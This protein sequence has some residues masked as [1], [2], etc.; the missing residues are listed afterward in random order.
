MP[1]VRAILPR[2]NIY[3]HTRPSRCPRCGGGMLHRHGEVQKRVKDIYV[4]EVAAMRYRCVGCGRSFTHY[5]QGVDRNGC[6]VRL[7]ALMSLMWALG[8]S[9]RSVGCVLTA[10]GRPA[11]RMSS[12][13]A[14]QEAG[15][16]AARSM[17]KR[18]M[19]GSAPVM[20]ADETIVKVRGKAKLAGFVA[21]AES[22][23]LLG[24][25]MPVE[26][27]GAGF[28]D[29]L[30]GYVE[31]LGVKAVVTDDL[32]TY[33]PVVDRLG[34]EHQICAAHVRKNA[35]RRLR[36]AQ[37]WQ[38]WKSRLRNLLDE[39]PDDG[40]KRLMSM[41]REVRDEPGLRRL[42]VDLCDKWR[43]LLC[44]KRARGVC[45]TNNVT[46]RVIGRSKIRYKTLRGY[47]SVEG[48]MNGLWLTQW[49]WGESDM[50]MGE[51]LAA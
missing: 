8:L 26:R 36:K 43:S 39:L 32:S 31:R 40:G 44:H 27:D 7:R 21:D 14:V 28:A 42:A 48:M 33:K 11:S 10:L 25:D 24:I 19:S 6:S 34:L 51:L 29:W 15:G 23:E 50:D 1:R 41:E 45:D 2:V 3:P 18:G 30:K 12:W 13:R 20:G 35:A 46:E 4:D 22:G 9:H 38:G 16:A 5:P 17:S 47:K 49:I 37:G